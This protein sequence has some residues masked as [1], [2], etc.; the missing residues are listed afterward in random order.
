MWFLNNVH[1]YDTLKMQSYEVQVSK[2]QT[3]IKPLPQ[4]LDILEK[5][6]KFLWKKRE[7]ARY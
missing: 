5:K 2:I 4:N 1:R 6:S 3:N 7:N